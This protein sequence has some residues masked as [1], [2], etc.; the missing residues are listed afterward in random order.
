MEENGWAATPI[1]AARP[2]LPPQEPVDPFAPGPFAF[3]DAKR[4][5]AIL[6]SAGFKDI[7]I[8][9]FDGH[10]DMAATVEEAALQDNDHRPPVA[11][12]GRTGRCR[13]GENSRCRHRSVEGLRDA[14]WRARAGGVLVCEGESLNGERGMAERNGIWAWWPLRFLVFFF[15]LA[16]PYIR[17][18]DAAVIVVAPKWHRAGVPKAADRGGGQ[19]GADRRDDGSAIAFSCA[20]WSGER[21][22]NSVGSRA[23]PLILGGAAIGVCCSAP[24]MRCCGPGRGVTFKGSDASTEDWPLR[25]AGAGAAIGEE[26]VFRGAVFR[27]FE[28]GFG[29]G[30]ARAFSPARCSGF[31]TPATGAT[32][33]SPSPSRSKRACCWPRPTRSRARCGFRSECISVGIS[34]KAESSA[35]RSPAARRA[36]A[37]ST[38]DLVGPDR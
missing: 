9:K 32:L 35:R 31:C 28:E 7:H 24:S 33:A 13:Q 12:D 22:A 14:A 21:P 10:M 27:L 11:R 25:C 16:S 6:S 2:L 17:L 5:E 38:R 3:A 20:G 23:V 4:V 18:P 36:K 1:K 37:Y 29:T 26:I 19:P 15:V 8:E 30:I 34:P